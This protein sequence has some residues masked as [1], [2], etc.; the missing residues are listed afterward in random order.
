MKYIGFLGVSMLIWVLFDTFWILFEYVGF[1]WEI[2]RWFF[3]ESY[4]LFNTDRSAQPGN[5]QIS[6]CLEINGFPGPEWA[7]TQNGP[8][9]DRDPGPKG[10]NGAG[11]RP[12]GPKWAGT[13]AQWAQMGRDPG[14]MGVYRSNSIYA[15]GGT[16][17]FSLQCGIYY[18]HN[19][20]ML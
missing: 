11:P 12:K 19:Y 10:P 3:V 16:I 4:S 8:K 17:I 1:I 2:M 13:Q 5:L 14:P 7:G 18:I 20:L 6:I 9:W 15:Q